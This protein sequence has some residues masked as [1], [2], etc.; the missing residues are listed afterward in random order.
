[1]SGDGVSR[2]ALDL[3]QGALQ[4]FVGKSLDLAA[5]LTD[6]MVVVLTARMH[7]LKAGHSRPNVDPLHQTPL[8]QQVEHAVDGRD[9]DGAPLGPQA[10]EDLLCGETAVL[11]AE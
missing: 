5:V 2:P 6:E 9:A 3:L 4:S 1:M 11:A 8:A 10:V 7:G